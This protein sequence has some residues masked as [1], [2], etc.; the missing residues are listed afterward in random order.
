MNQGACQDDQLAVGGSW[1]QNLDL[2]TG[3]AIT[4]VANA[5]RNVDADAGSIRYVANAASVGKDAGS[6][7]YVANISFWAA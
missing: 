5:T 7:R 2:R 1:S 4:V 6:I 3:A